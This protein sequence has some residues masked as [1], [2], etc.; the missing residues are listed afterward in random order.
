MWKPV[1]LGTHACRWRSPYRPP[2]ATALDFRYANG[3]GPTNTNNQCAIRTLRD[4]Q[5]R[6]LGTVVLPQRG[7]DAWNSWGY[8]NPLLVQLPAGRQILTLDYEPADTN[9]N[10]TTNQ[11]MLDCLRLTRLP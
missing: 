8:S 10:G 7:Q 4:A 2:A 11:A 9:M 5:G 6:Q 3:N 1:P